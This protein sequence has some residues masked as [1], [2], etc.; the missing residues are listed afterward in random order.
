MAL[1]VVAI[2]GR[3]NVGKSSLFNWLAGR[4]IS[5]VDPTAGVTRDRVSTV[6]EAGDRF[7]ELVDTGGMGVVDVDDLTTD[8]E[9]QISHALDSAALILFVVDVRDGV[10]PLD[11]KVGERLRALDRPVI[12][13][14]NKAD[15]PKL[16]IGTSDFYRLGYGEPFPVSA[17][18]GRNRD[19][20]LQTII[21]RLPPDTGEPPPGTANLKLAVVGRRN[22]GKSTFVNQLAREDRVIVSEIPGTTRDS[23]DVRI[24]RDGKSILVI[25]TAGVRKKTTLANDI[26]YYGLHRAQRSIRR[27]DVVL[28]FFD[29]SLRIGRVDKQLAE[30]IL[31]EHKPAIFVLNK[32]DLVKDRVGME[33]MGEY[34]R[35][36]FRMLDYVPIAFIT[37]KV[38]KNAQRLLHLATELHK[39]AGERL[40]TGTLN[41]ILRDAMNASPPPT[42]LGN[43]LGKVYY[44]AQVAS[45][46]PTIAF[47]VND[48]ELFDET[49]IRYLTKAIRDH[50]PFEEVPIKVILKP[51]NQTPKWASKEESE[52]DHSADAEPEAANPPPPKPR[53]KKKPSGPKTWNI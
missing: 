41:R 13:L 30:Y 18:N 19:T 40:T 52:S 20:L 34:V 44:V 42:R 24:E 8:V 38:G 46:P 7:F 12:F 36:V 15:D 6:I 35:K 37:A 32:W 3:P 1:P 27:A 39:Q 49:Y 22:A 2:V 26:E 31:E 48:P 45:N 4:R 51:R 11:Q 10:V 50:G 16:D 28:H 33:K 25:D 5:I 9:N 53:K 17:N 23:V 43:R 21:D 47:V 29:S 14:A